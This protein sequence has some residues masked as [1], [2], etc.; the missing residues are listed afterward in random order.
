MLQQRK[1]TEIRMIF[2]AVSQSKVY[3]NGHKKE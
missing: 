1:G 3:L 2:E